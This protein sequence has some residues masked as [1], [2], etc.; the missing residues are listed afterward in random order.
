VRGSRVTVVE[1]MQST[2]LL[3][4]T[5]VVPEKKPD[6]LLV[7][8]GALGNLDF[9]CR[10]PTGCN[11]RAFNIRELPDEPYDYNGDGDLFAWGLRNSVGIA[12]S[13]DGAIWSVENGPDDVKRDNQAIH[14]DNPA[15]ELNYHGT[16][17]TSAMQGKNYGYPECFATWDT[18]IP[19]AKVEVADQ[20]TPSP[21]A[22]FT[23]ATCQQKFEKPALALEAHTAP[24]DIKFYR[25]DLTGGSCESNA[26]SGGL[27][28]EFLD[29]AFIANHGAFNQEAKSG[30]SVVTVPFKSFKPEAAQTDTRAAKELLWPADIGECPGKCFRPVGIAFDSNGRMFV[31][32][33]TTKELIVLTQSPNGKKSA[34]PAVRSPGAWAM[35]LL[36]ALIPAALM[37]L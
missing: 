4:R 32:S 21:N 19:G 3:T 25:P 10:E 11:I 24:L 17:F 18:S 8:M 29:D 20:F 5:L 28:C 33:D 9:E 35:G 27:G 12:E 14:E 37:V 22:T 1:G 36:A 31:T 2:G 34:A 23:D 13:G 26:G 7:Q 16:L 6:T 30:Y 15:E